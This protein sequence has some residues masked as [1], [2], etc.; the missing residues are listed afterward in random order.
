MID[1]IAARSNTIEIMSTTNIGIIL[2]EEGPG[3]QIKGGHSTSHQRPRS[4]L[5][6]SPSLII[7]N[8][9]CVIT[10]VVIVNATLG[11]LPHKLGS[12]A[13][14]TNINYPLGDI[15]AYILDIIQWRTEGRR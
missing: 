14:M 1:G 11:N 6:F 8:I 3:A 13:A 4:M 9:I 2:Q 7:T 10:K 15:R 5:I 12:M